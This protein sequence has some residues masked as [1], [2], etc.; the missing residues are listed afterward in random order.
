MLYISTL[1]DELLQERKPL[2]SMQHTNER[3]STKEMPP[4]PDTVVQCRGFKFREELSSQRSP[5]KTIRSCRSR[6]DEEGEEQR[7]TGV[8]KPVTASQPVWAGKPVVLQPREEPVTISVN[9][10]DP[11]E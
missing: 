9:A 10:A 3:K 11:T 8:P 7:L 1:G 4:L 5:T 2:L 6:D